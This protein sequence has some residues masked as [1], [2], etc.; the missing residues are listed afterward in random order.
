MDFQ[1]REF[2]AGFHVD[3][4]PIGAPVPCPRV[5][6]P[7]ALV[8]WTLPRLAAAL[9]MALLPVPLQRAPALIRRRRD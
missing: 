2:E 8:P 7:E 3:A 4:A 5:M 9:V 1:S 6:V